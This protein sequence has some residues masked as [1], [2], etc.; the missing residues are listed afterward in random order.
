MTPTAQS[1]RSTAV[2]F[3]LESA[4]RTVPLTNASGNNYNVGIASTNP[5]RFMILDPSRGFPVKPQFNAAKKELDGDFEVRRNILEAKAY[6]GEFT[7]KFDSENLYFMLLGL[8]GKDVQTQV[9]FSSSGA[10]N[11]VF[12]HVLTPNSARGYQP[13]FTIE[14]I[15]GDGTTGRLTS[16]CIVQK[17]VFTFGLTGTVTGSIYG[18][19]QIPNNYPNSLNSYTDYNFTSS[20][21]VLPTQ[22]GG[23]GT[24]QIART[25]SPTYVDVAEPTVGGGNLG[26]GP[27]AWGAALNGTA[28][29]A[30]ATNFLTIDGSGVAV[31]ILPGSTISIERVIERFQPAGSGFD[32]GATAGHEWDVTGKLDILFQ[33]N[34]VPLAVMRKSNLGLNFKFQGPQIGTTGFYYTTEFYI[35]RFNLEDGGVELPATAIMTGGTFQGKK[36]LSGI[37]GVS[38]LNSSIRMVLTNTVDNTNLA[39]TAGST[40]AAGG[41]GGWNN[42]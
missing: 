9:A 25:A 23:D 4:W 14:E 20:F 39:G 5:H 36:D 2:G 13:S 24:K 1:G 34:T 35:P 16:G 40:G 27:M 26:N 28:G 31:E 3:C 41:L 33:D 8:F 37:A 22:M 30:Y 10:S 29:G 11:S 42:S 12:Q 21:A 38:A 18:Y 32:M 15:F 19:R 6:D 7:M 17:V